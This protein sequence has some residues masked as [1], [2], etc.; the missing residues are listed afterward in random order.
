MTIIIREERSPLGT[1]K[2]YE[3]KGCRRMGDDARLQEGR[4]VSFERSFVSCWQ[5]NGV[6]HRGLQVGR[7]REEVE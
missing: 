2:G 6:C 7:E 1:K 3:R 5:E 4:N